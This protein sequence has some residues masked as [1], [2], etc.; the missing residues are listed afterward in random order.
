MKRLLFVDDQP[1]VLRATRRMLM[2][3]SDGWELDFADNGI[4][5][6]EKLDEKTFDVVISDMKMPGMNGAQLL[7]EIGRKHPAVI[8]IVLSGYAE[9]D[10]V[11]KTIGHAH[12][13]LS[14]PISSEVL[15]ETLQ[16]AL[17]LRE[18]LNHEGLRAV[19]TSMNSLPS[20]PNAYDALMDALYAPDA[21]LEKVGKAIATDIGMTAKIMQIVNSSFFGLPTHISDPVQATNLLGIEIIR[22][23]VVSVHVF[24]TF[25]GFDKQTFS[26]ARFNQ[27]SLLV[28]G[29]AKAIATSS[30]LDQSAIDDAFIAG[31]MHDIGKLVVAAN[32]P[33]TYTENTLYAAE[34]GITLAHSEHDLIQ[35]THAEIG[36]YLLGLWGF[37]DNI[38]EAVAYHHSPDAC[39]AS[40]ITPL[41][42]VHLADAFEKTF[43]SE[44]SKLVH[45]NIDKAYLEK[46]GAIDKIDT[47]YELCEQ[48]K[49]EV[50]SYD[51]EDTLC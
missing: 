12:Q 3:V 6:L 44:Y 11:F 19:V 25:D 8:R 10:L 32:L 17:K 13:Y 26:L 14:K 34:K 42:A 1:Q 15:I 20:M 50:V 51:E 41:T 31:L 47:W 35:T 29:M 4:N 9:H 24:S 36:A 39:V 16:R 27:H 22:A 33:A 46:I 21:S 49:P 43:S 30:K 23:L 40:G 28:G 37:R 7:N 5:A 48:M 38:V 45:P 18:L 2:S